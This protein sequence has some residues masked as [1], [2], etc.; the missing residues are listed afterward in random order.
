MARAN[1]LVDGSKIL[2]PAITTYLRMGATIVT[3]SV[4]TGPRGDL[5][6]AIARNTPPVVGDTEV[7]IQIFKKPLIVWLWIGGLL[8]AVGTVLSAF[9]GKRRRDPLAPVSA[10]VPT[11]GAPPVDDI[12]DDG[13]PRSEV[14]PVG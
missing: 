9:P 7:A 8:M 12:A 13:E 11:G 4:R 2:G 1:V 6:L 10:A 3:P 14:T 5:Y